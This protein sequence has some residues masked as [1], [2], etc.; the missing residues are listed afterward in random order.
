MTTPIERM[1][2]AA[3]VC[4][5]CGRKMGDAACTCWD[6]MTIECPVCGRKKTCERIDLDPS[7][8]VRMVAVCPRCPGAEDQIVRWYDANGMESAY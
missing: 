1:I 4:L 5:R 3:M 6:A 8:A 2:D 7:T